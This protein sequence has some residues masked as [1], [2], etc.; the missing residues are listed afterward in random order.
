MEGDGS[1]W[2]G[3]LWTT[4]ARPAD[5]GAALV[6]PWKNSETTASRRPCQRRCQRMSVVWMCRECT[7]HAE[8]AALVAVTMTRYV[9]P[10]FPDY[11]CPESVAAETPTESGTLP[12]DMNAVGVAAVAAVTS[13]DDLPKS[14]DTADDSEEPVKLPLAPMPYRLQLVTSCANTCLKCLPA[15]HSPPGVCT[16][17]AFLLVQ[18]QSTRRCS[19]HPRDGCLG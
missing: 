2:A 4:T 7:S 9:R 16:A 5:G 10:V 11:G 8:V 6:T 18:W 1:R 3:H 12:N 14:V 15:Q 13:H 19:G 17:G